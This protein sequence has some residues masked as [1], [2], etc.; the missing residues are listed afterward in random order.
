MKKPQ[1]FFDDLTDVY[2]YKLKGVGPPSYHLGGTF[3]RDKDGTLS[4]GAKRY[5]DKILEKFERAYG[6]KPK[7]YTS[8]VDDK[9]SHELD[10]SPLLDNDGISK[11]QSL[12]G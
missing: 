6:H 10:S 4:W 8:P 1:Q 11:C 3:E 9:D 5:I 2:K 12:I 7:Q